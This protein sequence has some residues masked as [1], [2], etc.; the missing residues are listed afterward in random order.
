MELGLVSDKITASVHQFI[1]IYV[2]QQLFQTSQTKLNFETYCL[3][4]P[5]FVFA[6]L[7]IPSCDGLRGVSKFR[8]TALIIG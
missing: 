6:V 8:D 1:E 3:S 2:S 5:P 4:L 7:F